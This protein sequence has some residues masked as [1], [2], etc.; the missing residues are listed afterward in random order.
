MELCLSFHLGLKHNHIDHICMVS[1]LC[2]FGYVISV[3]LVFG[4]SFGSI[5]TQHVA[6]RRLYRDVCADVRE[7]FAFF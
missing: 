1:P 4:I 5:R 6:H 7:N 3:L 2:V